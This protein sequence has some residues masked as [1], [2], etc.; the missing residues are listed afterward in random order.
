M[1]LCGLAGVVQGEDAAPRTRRVRFTYSAEVREVP[2]GAREVMLWLPFPPNDE[3]QE[4]SNIVVRS[5]VPTSV[6]RA[7]ECGNQ[8]LSLNVQNPGRQ[9][10]RVELQFDVARRERHNAAAVARKP[11]QAPAVD[12]KISE[13]WLARDKLVPIDGKV[14]DLAREVTRGHADDLD[15]IRAIYDHTVSTLKYD[16]SGT[17]WGR[18]DIAYACDAKRGNCTDFHAVFIGLCRAKGIP[19]RFEIGFSLPTDKPAGE[20]SGYHCWADCHV[21]GYGWIPVDCSEAQKHPERREYFFGAHDEHRV[22]F[23][24]G[25]DIRLN[26]AQRGEPLN[27]FVYPYAE[28]DGKPHEKIDRK[29]RYE[30]L[31]K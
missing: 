6:N 28:V 17:G 26:P 9:P 11:V 31:V 25:R 27:Y 4:I 22:A 10:V 15:Q 19:A 8:V 1:L 2:A 18:G 24:T 29:I 23:S 14:L 13:R 7:E 20:I 21:A 3:W 5:D 12:E 16:K 30:D